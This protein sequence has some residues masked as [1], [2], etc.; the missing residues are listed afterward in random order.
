MVEDFWDV[1]W[2]QGKLYLAT[3]F[4]LWT[5][6]DGVLTPVD[7]GDD[8]PSSCNRLSSAEDTLWSVG[9]DDVFCF[10]GTEWTRID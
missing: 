3:A 2:F 8:A 10:D 5:L 9:A 4:G 6:E 1:H 7:F